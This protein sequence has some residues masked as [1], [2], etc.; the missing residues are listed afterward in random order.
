MTFP[1][2]ST[3]AEH[4]LVASRADIMKKGNHGGFLPLEWSFSGTC[5]RCLG[6]RWDEEGKEL[7][8]DY[9]V[10]RSS[11]AHALVTSRADNM[12]KGN[13]GGFLPLELFSSGGVPAQGRGLIKVRKEICY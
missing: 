1:L 8:S 12:K 11:L 9:H 13:H 4:A 3:V 10:A 7:S 6:R 5:P 2:E